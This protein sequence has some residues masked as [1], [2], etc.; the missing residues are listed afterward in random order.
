TRHRH[1][2]DW[3]SASISQRCADIWTLS[4]VMSYEPAETRQIVHIH[5]Q[6]WG[7]LWT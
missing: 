7:R 5:R 6:R 4:A 2:P 3:T 1:R